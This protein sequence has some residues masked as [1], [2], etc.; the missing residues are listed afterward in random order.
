MN[1]LEEL[2]RWIAGKIKGWSSRV[3]GEPRGRE[4]LEIRLEILE[5]VRAEIEP[6]GGGRS[7]FLTAPS[8]FASRLRMSANALR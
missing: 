1:A 8:G 2:D 6:K 5:R 3:S 4:L 7:V